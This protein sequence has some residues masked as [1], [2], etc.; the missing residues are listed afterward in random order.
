VSDEPFY[1]PTYRPPKRQPRPGELLF[2]FV[3]ADHVRVR[4]ELRDHG[5]YGVEVQIFHNEELFAGY[6][7]PARAL[8]VAW[9]ERERKAMER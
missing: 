4:V 2:E 5:A 6:R 9:A 7:H 1:S 8:A 3:R